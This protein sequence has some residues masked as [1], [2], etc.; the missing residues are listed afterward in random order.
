MLNKSS[1]LF[2]KDLAQHNNKEWFA[3]NRGRYESAKSDL[4]TLVDYLIT[5]VGRFE[6]LGNIRPKDC[7]FR[8]NRDIRFSKNKDPYKSFLSA[9]IGPGGRNS[10]RIDY[11]VHIQP[12]GESFLGGGMW[13]ATPAQLNKFRQEVDY[14]AH[15]LKTIIENPVFRAFFPLVWG[16]KLKTAPK[17]YPK[18]HPEIDLL[19]RK[20]LFFMH[21][22]TDEEVIAPGFPDRVIE[23]IQLL[24]P[25]TDFL[26]Y[27]FFDEEEE[28]D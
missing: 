23:G 22:F 14:N 24:K 15:Q 26:N 28:Q 9:A 25:Y 1:L 27:V 7:I 21:K 4:E 5:N 12:H 16:E 6:D 10:G 8:I 13:E 2:L 17:G 11:Y 3:E 18:D 19:Q 20:Q